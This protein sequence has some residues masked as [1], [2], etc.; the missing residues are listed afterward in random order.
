MRFY[1]CLTLALLASSVRG[2]AELIQD[3]FQCKKCID[4]GRKFCPS[5]SRY[6]QGYCCEMTDYCPAAIGCT[7]EFDDLQQK[8]LLCP[9]KAS[10][11]VW[12]RKPSGYNSQPSRFSQTSLDNKQGDLCTFEITPPI[13]ADTNDVLVLEIEFLRGVIATLF[14]GGSISKPSHRFELGQGQKYTVKNGE[15]LYLQ[16]ETYANVGQY[17][18]SIQYFIISGRAKFEP[19]KATPPPG[20]VDPWEE[21]IKEPE[22]ED[23]SELD[24]WTNDNNSNNNGSNPSGPTKPSGNNNSTFID[25]KNF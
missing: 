4:E 17:A 25:L 12:G 23:G 11:G 19:S 18:F 10:C 22:P 8:Y 6:Q 9:N 16:L 1:L 5:N 3:S 21:V 2:V 7:D 24:Q 13:S 15:T 14:K 20:W